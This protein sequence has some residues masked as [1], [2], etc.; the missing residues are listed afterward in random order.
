MTSVGKTH[1][2]NMKFTIKYSSDFLTKTLI[3][4]K[5]CLEKSSYKYKFNIWKVLKTNARMKLLTSVNKNSILSLNN[6][7]IHKLS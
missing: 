1:N 4:R 6:F 7:L 5:R 2:K 3:K